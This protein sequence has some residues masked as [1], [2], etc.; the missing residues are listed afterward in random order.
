MATSRLID[1]LKRTGA[2]IYSSTL[3]SSLLV[4][5]FDFRFFVIRRRKGLVCNRH[6]VTS[7]TAMLFR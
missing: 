1:E 3:R 4:F 7:H 6:V 2:T 5:V